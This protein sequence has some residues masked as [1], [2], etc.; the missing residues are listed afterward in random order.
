MAGT[1]MHPENVRNVSTLHSWQVCL[2]RAGAENRAAKTNVRHIRISARCGIETDPSKD[3]Q[4]EEAR[5]CVCYPV[6]SA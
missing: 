4:T 3:E 5:P 6:G 1:T 2:M